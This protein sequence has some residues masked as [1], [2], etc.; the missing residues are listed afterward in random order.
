MMILLI[1]FAPALALAQ[2]HAPAAHW[3]TA[4]G[5]ADAGGVRLEVGGSDTPLCSDC[6]QL[7]LAP[8]AGAAHLRADA[9]R[10]PFADRSIDL[11]VTKNF[12]WNAEF[13][14]YLRE[15]LAD[16]QGRTV[17]AVLNEYHRVLSPGG[18]ALLMFEYVDAADG[19]LPDPRRNFATHLAV[20][21]ELGLSVARLRAV[22]FDRVYAEPPTYS[23]WP[24]RALRPGAREGLDAYLASLR[25]K[26]GTGLRRITSYLQGFVLTRT[27]AGILT[28]AS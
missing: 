19:S 22:A 14:M 6:L 1:L 10:L 24:E 2:M 12:P 20:A 3:L 23:P 28:Q 25:L 27:C 5:L 4:F 7:D 18:R 15:D 8:A 13:L 11:I 26:D 21:A 9:R 17:A 16:A